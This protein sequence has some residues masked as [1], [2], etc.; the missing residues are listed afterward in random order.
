MDRFLC[1]MGKNI[2]SFISIFDL[3]KDLVFL[4]EADGDSFKY[5][6]VNESA[7]EVLHY[8]GSM[9]GKRIEDVVSKELAKTLIIKYQ[10][11]VTTLK[12]VEFEEEYK[13]CDGRF[14]GETSLNPI[15]IGEEEC[16]Y[17]LGIV[18]DVTERRHRECEL[19]ETKRQ[20][21][22]NQKK[23]ISLVENNG[24]AVFEVDPNGHFIDINVMGHHLTGYCGGELNGQSFVPLVVEDMREEVISHFKK[25]LNGSKEEYETV[26]YNR[27]GN[28]VH[29]F[30]KNV[31]VYVDDEIVGV[32]G[33][34]KD[35][36]ERK[37][38]QKA[39]ERM[40]FYDYLTGLPN[41]RTFDDRLDMA[42]ITANHTNKKIAVMMLDGRKFKKVNDTYG[43][44][45]GDAVIRQFAMRLKES[46][47]AVDT[48]ARFGGDEMA[49]ILPE[50]ES[51]EMVEEIAK[52]IL[53]TLGKP[54][55]FKNRKINL[56]AGIGISIYPDHSM[57]KRRLIKY[58]DEA[59]YEAKES[60]WDIYRF[61]QPKQRK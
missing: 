25:A 6:Y 55:T 27:K 34:A 44:D 61:Y 7:K 54:F 35:I 50:I 56:G 23:L 51:L 24:D 4:M 22:N 37:K 47:R 48:V 19:K 5:I 57:K 60:E 13:G 1:K 43:H 41:R 49:V 58:A 29:L 16:I 52:Q 46:V 14:I 42:I 31:P 11:T 26:I 33:I 40:A 12:T 20:L 45:A 18:R 9:I 59:L 38:Q 15:L 21:E 2:T 39:L 8:R 10:Q 36:T 3:I 17:I 28:R 32:Y 30:V 53:E